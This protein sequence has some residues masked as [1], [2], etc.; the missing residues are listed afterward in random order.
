MTDFDSLFLVLWPEQRE[1]VTMDELIRL[2]KRAEEAEKAAVEKEKQAATKAAGPVDQVPS[3]SSGQSA[4]K[5]SKEKG[6][7]ISEGGPRTTPSV[8]AD[9]APQSKK[10]G[11]KRMGAQAEAPPAVRQRTSPG[12]NVA[13]VPV[14]V[15]E[16]TAE[17]LVVHPHPLFGEMIP[18]KKDAPFPRQGTAS[19]LNNPMYALK[20]ARSVVP[21][22]DRQYVLR[23][24]VATVLSDMIDLSMKVI[25]V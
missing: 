9:P 23:R 20:L 22:P 2:Q 8:P 19:L 12:G 25:I 6:I 1:M 11:K 16:L 24:N 14:S 15:S 4:A 5:K 10:D 13:M 18:F 7:T 17:K 3:E 21:V